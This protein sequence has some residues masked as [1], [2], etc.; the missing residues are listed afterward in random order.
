MRIPR[1]VITGVGFV[2]SI[3]NDR[4]GVTTSLRDLNTGIERFDMLPGTDLP[5]KV[6]GTIKDF[7]TTAIQW[8]AWRWP[9]GY[10]FPQETLRGMPPHGLYALCAIEQANADSGLTSSEIAS[11]ETSLFCASAGSPRLL[12]YYANQLHDSKGERVSPM[13]IVSSI[14]GTLNFNLGAYLGIKG[15]VAG[16]SSACASTTQAI[17]YACDEIALGRQR[18]VLVVGGEDVNFDSLMPFSGMRALSRQS[19]PVLASRPF[20]VGRD[21]FVG[22]GGAVALWLEAA[23]TAQ[24]RG[25]TIYAELL[26]WGQS[27]DGTS[28]AQSDPDGRGLA[29]A[30]HRALRAAKVA[31]Q[32]VS[33]V[34]AHA[35]S[36]QAG[37]I[38]EARALRSI[39]ANS[40]ASPAISSTKALTGHG[41][42]LSGVMET[43]F[44]A[45]CL[46]EGFVPGAANLREVD[47]ACEGLNLPRTSLPSAPRIV[48]K[49][50]SG[51]GGSNVSL[52]LARWES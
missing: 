31:P 14:A 51:F 9:K 40:G 20:D 47:P 7:D 4:A 44:C 34:N 36:T 3:G 37:D 22:T 19:D 35:T 43:A 41:L 16:F 48:V 24:A 30:M 1:I 50:S 13:S 45:V 38:S 11:E 23:E 49:N 6:A 32:D 52:V 10:K 2:T 21:G 8:A 42:S 39:F 18:R 46:A 15:A 27:A 25:A 33:Y 29:L 26:G 28:V 12:R 17:G 5:V